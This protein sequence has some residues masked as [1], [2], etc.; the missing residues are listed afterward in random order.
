MGNACHGWRGEGGTN[1]HLAL[2]PL[3]VS[4]R[5]LPWAKAIQKHL[6]ARGQERWD[7]AQRSEWG[8][9][10]R[11]ENRSGAQTQRVCLLHSYV[12]DLKHIFPVGLL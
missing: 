2:L 12:W 7:A 8:L 6:E 1:P 4:G 9:A 3:P 5:C 10:R 11:R